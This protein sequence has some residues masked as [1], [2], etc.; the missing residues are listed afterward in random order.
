MV[1]SR[2]RK[3]GYVSKLLLVA[4]FQLALSLSVFSQDIS[5]KASTDKSDYLV[6]DYINYTIQVHCGKI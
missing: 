6:G 3:P 5:A 4:V 1:R 2:S